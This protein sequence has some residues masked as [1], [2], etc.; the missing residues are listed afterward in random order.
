MKRSNVCPKCQG[1]A[2]VHLPV[3]TDAGDWAGDSE[4]TLNDRRG[5]HHVSRALGL[6]F[7]KSAG[8]L[9]DSDTYT[10]VAETEAYICTGCGYA[11]EYVKDAAS[12]PWG[13]VVG[14]VRRR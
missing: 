10:P 2:I 6:V 3:V 13:D 8:G 5:I 1:V 7:K 11:E 12:V 4:G 9:F 14:A